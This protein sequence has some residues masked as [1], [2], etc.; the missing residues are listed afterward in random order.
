MPW[1][2]VKSGSG[3]KVRNKDTGKTYSKK[4]MTKEKAN[5]QLR[6]LYAN[7]KE[8]RSHFDKL[9]QEALGKLDADRTSD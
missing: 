3:Y 4:S 8:S 6:A 7:V 9:L 2:V 5:R 1:S